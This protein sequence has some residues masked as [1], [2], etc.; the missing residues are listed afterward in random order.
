[1]DPGDLTKQ[2]LEVIRSFDPV[3]HTVDVHSDQALTRLGVRDLDARAFIQQTFYG[4]QRCD[5]PLRVFI[6][7][8]FHVCGGSLPRA[9]MH[10]FRL[11]GYLAIFRLDELSWE[12]FAAFLACQEVS[13]M[14]RF[15]SFLWDAALV[16]EWLKEGWCKFLDRSYVEGTLLA[17]L[18][19]HRPAAE[20]WLARHRD[21]AFGAA[22]SGTAR[23]AA[24]AAGSGGA[25]DSGTPGRRKGGLRPLTVPVAP[26]LT[27]PRP[28][29]LPEPIRIPQAVRANAMP[30]NLEDL[31][32][33][34]LAAEAEARR[35]AARRAVEDK[36]APST[37]AG[38]PSL[39]AVRSNI[40]LV[41]AEVDA[42]RA[43]ELKFEGMPARR[44]PPLPTRPGGEPSPSSGGLG[45]GPLGAGEVR[46]NAAAILREEAV[47]RKAQAADAAEL[48]RY[49]R[50][51]RDGREHA[52]WVA[53]QR[54]AEEAA[55]A[56][57]REAVRVELAAGARIAAAAQAALAAS[58]A[59]AA[60]RLR[61]EARELAAGKAS[62]AEAEAV[63]RKGLAAAVRA[64]TGAAPIV[65]RSETIASKRAA[66]EAAREA[67]AAALA[68]AEASAAADAAERASLIKQ[69]RAA[70]AAGTAR[71]AAARIKSVDPTATSGVR[72][73]EEMSL[74]ELRERLLAVRAAADAAVADRRAAILASK[75]AAQEDMRQ[76]IA[77]LATLR[78]SA[79]EAAAA[80]RMSSAAARA[81]A[82]VAAAEARE[83]SALALHERLR[84]KAEAVAAE[85]ERL[86]A[87][88]ARIAKRNL[89][90]GA[91]RLAV[92][93]RRM[94]A[95]S[96]AAERRAAA[97]QAEALAAH[98]A[99]QRVKARGAADAA[100]HLAATQASALSRLLD[101]EADATTAARE[102]RAF[103]VDE[104]S[105]RADA[106]LHATEAEATLL[107]LRD[108]AD[109]F[110]A[111]VR[112][113]ERETARAARGALPHDL[114]ATAVL[115]AR[116]ERAPDG[117]PLKA[118]MALR[119]SQRVGSLA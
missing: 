114:V 81:A 64:V 71:A 1:M 113:H 70:E 40:D 39:R 115:A 83:D 74:V 104:A 10:L 7:A 25:D 63:S 97:T 36:Y 92:E 116:T 18:E 105:R 17:S 102:A 94:R 65:A 73:L 52:E 110:A 57:K 109:P 48:A 51:L 90:L 47:F 43:A 53:A 55:A 119:L 32:L 13:K 62:A 75:R 98:A 49:E 45:L 11:Y 77:H 12:R 100:S 79:A 41:R 82:A 87:E 5:K 101:S 67:A 3:V 78:A 37:G 96:A 15:V 35:E 6:D 30:G 108:M 21:A 2:A 22:G 42:A 27:A 91:G 72:V 85:R 86:R 117:S 38:A 60:D 112:A 9:D 44:P 31:T 118:T 50:E 29:A 54:A 69:L 66:A 56:A 16:N 14:Y 8:L 28:R 107:A 33:D 103:R 46:L 95:V 76:R 59:S 89:F 111:A 24:A 19:R 34:D 58:K 106:F 68:Q 61:A 93:E 23:G 80:D 26:K 20:R 99:S 88:S 4:T 84:E